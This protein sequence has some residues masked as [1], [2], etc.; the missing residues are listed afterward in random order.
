LGNNQGQADQLE[1]ENQEEEEIN[2]NAQWDL[3]A[4]Q[5]APNVAWDEWPPQPP[6]QNL[7]NMEIDLNNALPN[8]QPCG[9]S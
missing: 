4:A 1:E 5:N 3:L 9:S 2:P 7:E 8:H 6:T